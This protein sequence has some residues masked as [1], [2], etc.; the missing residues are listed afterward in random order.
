MKKIQ[1]NYQINTDNYI[2]KCLDISHS[3]EVTAYI[4]ENKEFHKRAMP[5]RD[6]KFY[7]EPFQIFVLEEEFKLS[8]ELKMIRF[9][10]FDKNLNNIFGDLV[11]SDIKTGYISSCSIGIKIDKKHIKKGI[12]SECLQKVIDFLFTTLNIQRIEANIMPDNLPSLNL[13]HKLGFK[14]EG[15]A[16]SYF[17]TDGVWQDHLRFSLIRDDII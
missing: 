2:I 12:A 1:K 10:I 14:K 17:F 9:Y 16:R 7:T 13:F 5:H 8:Q 15:I 11:V 3:Y 4:N 6:K